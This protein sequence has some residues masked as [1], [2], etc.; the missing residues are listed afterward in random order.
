MTSVEVQQE[1]SKY[2]DCK[3]VYNIVAVN[4]S[5][6][7]SICTTIIINLV[8]I[9]DKVELNSDCNDNTGAHIVGISFIMLLVFL[10][11][12]GLCI[13]AFLCICIIKSH[14]EYNVCC[15]NGKIYI[16]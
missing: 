12:M 2:S 8:G 11:F 3:S 14:I 4:S 13:S 1:C 7:P 6:I 10:I 5:I 16:N 15:E 9:G